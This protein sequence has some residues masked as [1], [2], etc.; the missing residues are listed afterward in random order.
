ME[1]KWDN[2][3]PADFKRLF[4]SGTYICTTGHERVNVIFPVGVLTVTYYMAAFCS[5]AQWH[6]P[7]HKARLES[8]RCGEECIFGLRV[9]KSD[10]MSAIFSAQ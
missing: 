7:T 1:K 10:L 4:V 2:L 8:W 5:F 3:I 9:L 6:A